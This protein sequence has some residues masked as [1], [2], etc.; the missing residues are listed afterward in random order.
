MDYYKKLS[1]DLS[2]AL[3]SVPLISGIRQ[4]GVY[5]M[6]VSFL[7][8]LLSAFT[9][10]IGGFLITLFKYTFMF[11]LLLLFIEYLNNYLLLG[12][13]GYAITRLIS[14]LF[15][16]NWPDFAALILFSWLGYIVF[17]K[18]GEIKLNG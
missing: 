6:G 1:A 15:R 8:I 14:L 3:K 4:Y 9:V 5:I 18:I 13:W 16:F 17:K 7:F 11:S 10:P 12:L 2:S